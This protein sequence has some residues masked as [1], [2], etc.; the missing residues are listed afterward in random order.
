MP[1]GS[2]APGREVVVGRR[3]LTAMSAFVPS[4]APCIGRQNTR[5]GQPVIAL[6]RPAQASVRC[7]ILLAGTAGQQAFATGV[8]FPSR[9][10]LQARRY[11]NS[12]PSSL[13]LISCRLYDTFIV[14]GFVVI[15]I[16][17]AATMFSFEHK[18]E[19][20]LLR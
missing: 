10:P 8:S 12:E 16:S 11:Q 20:R 4:S 6:A 17:L 9:R 15:D 3:A 2:K 5:T 13:A 7:G 14:R 1:S 19:P 18:L